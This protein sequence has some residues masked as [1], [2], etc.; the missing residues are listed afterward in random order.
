MVVKAQSLDR[1][2]EEVVIGNVMY[3]E[4]FLNNGQ[5]NIE[6]ELKDSEGGLEII[7]E[8]NYPD[9]RYYNV[10]KTGSVYEAI[11]NKDRETLAALLEQGHRVK[12]DLGE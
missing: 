5:S 6:F 8:D 7:E 12:Q 4:V 1:L 2:S 9:I 3:G 10:F 11:K